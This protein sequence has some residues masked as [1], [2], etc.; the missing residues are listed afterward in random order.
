MFGVV[1]LNKTMTRNEGREFNKSNFV[2]DHGSIG[3]GVN[4][5]GG[6]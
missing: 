1:D 5:S 3:P 2:R 4:E 6:G